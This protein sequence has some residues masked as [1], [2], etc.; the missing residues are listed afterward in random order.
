MIYF[1]VYKSITTYFDRE[2]IGTSPLSIGH[3]NFRLKLKLLSN[4]A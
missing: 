2:N 1:F 4:I 3:Y